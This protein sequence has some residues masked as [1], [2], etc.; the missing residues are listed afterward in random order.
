MVEDAKPVQEL[1][2]AVMKS[3]KTDERLFSLAGFQLF[4]VYRPKEGNDVG[5][6]SLAFTVKLQR[7]DQAVNDEEADSAMNAVLE[8]LES[9][10]ATL[11]K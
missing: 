3:R 11:R 8:V 9:C 10:G 7:L 6:K 1:V 4:D 5:M 2:D